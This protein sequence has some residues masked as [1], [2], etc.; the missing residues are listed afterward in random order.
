ISKLLLQFAPD[1]KI[2]FSLD[3]QGM[4]LSRRQP[5]RSVGANVIQHSCLIDQVR[6]QLLRLK[7]LVCRAI[8]FLADLLTS[9][10][11]VDPTP[12]TAPAHLPQH[13]FVDLGLLPEQRVSTLQPGLTL[14][15]LGACAS[16]SYLP[17]N[18]FSLSVSNSL[19]AP[20]HTSDS[21]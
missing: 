7:P 16:F 8:V 2:G 1:S 17:G 13:M 6:I 14:S 3:L 21:P 18:G 9:A 20:L 5:P 4:R 12:V 15:R 11:G 10:L 19:P